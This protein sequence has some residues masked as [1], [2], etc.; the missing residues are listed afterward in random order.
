MQSV[1][2]SPAYLKKRKFLLILPLL[3]LPFIVLLFFSM[4]G[5]QGIPVSEAAKT[6]GLNLQ[7]PDAHFIKKR[8][9][10]KL[11]LYDL[12]SQD[13]AKWKEALKND[14]YRMGD[15]GPVDSMSFERSQTLKDILDKSVSG[16]P[17]KGFE[18][19]NPSLSKR[20]SEERENEIKDKLSRLQTI[21]NSKPRVSSPEFA[22]VTASNPATEKLSGLVKE[23]N[24]GN[25][26]DPELSR[27]ER[28]LDK[29]MAIQHPETVQDSL[30]L[31][32]GK[33]ETVYRVETIGGDNAV[34]AIIP[35]KQTL[36]SG[37]TIRLQ[38]TV[39]VTL[40]G[41]KIPSD[42]FIY[43]MAML[44]NERLKIQVRSIRVENNILPVS[45]DIYDLDGMEGIYVP[46]S[47]SR[48]VS[49]QS[50]DQS[51]S[52]LGL[53]TLDPS[54]GAQAATAGIQAAKTLI[55][56]K[57]KQVQVTV[58]NDYRILLKNTQ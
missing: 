44:S 8:E 57:V 41:I 15:A 25:S 30:H 22:S 6:G 23:V 26:T 14:P 46:G 31:S 43:G 19:F 53:T 16:L 37:A 33:K 49:K 55:S 12:A 32:P 10:D 21:V 51:V 13:S 58:P 29:V 36:I 9:I 52:E 18:K 20:G 39:P 56:R 50:L 38:L 11:G 54:F 17:E 27:L 40:G 45:L 47:I 2:Q 3:V 7:L 35:E 42:Q 4:G 34:S 24:S 5:G 48:D 1:I 28:M